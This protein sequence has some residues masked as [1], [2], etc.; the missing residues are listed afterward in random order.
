VVRVLDWQKD[1]VASTGIALT[2]PCMHHYSQKLYSVVIQKIC[3]F[4][5]KQ[6]STDKIAT[7]ALFRLEEQN[8]RRKPD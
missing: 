3:M 8:S 6:D 7:C 2:H 1:D 4:F 5:P